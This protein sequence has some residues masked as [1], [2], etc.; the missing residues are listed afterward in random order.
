M[1]ASAKLPLLNPNEFEL[2][3]MRI[4]QYFLMKDYALWEVILNGDSLL[5]TRFVDGV[6]K[7]YPPIRSVK[8]YSSN[9]N[10]IMKSFNPNNLP[11][12]LMFTFRIFKF[13]DLKALSSSEGCIQTLHSEDRGVASIVTSSSSSRIISKHL[14]S[15]A[16]SFSSSNLCLLASSCS[17]LLLALLELPSSAFLLPSA[18][19]SLNFVPTAVITNSCK[20][21]V[22]TAKQSSLRAAASTSTARNINTAATRPTVNDAKPSSNDQ[23]I[24]DSE[25]SR[26]ITGNKSFLIDYQEINGG[27][28]AFGGSPKGDHLGKFKG[29]AD[30][31]FLVAYSVNRNQ[32]NDDVGIEINVNVKQAGQEKASDHEYILLSFMPFHSPL[33]LSIQ[34]SDDKDADEAPGKGDEGLQINQKDVGIFISHDKYVANI[35]KKFDFTTVKTTSTPIEPNKALIKDAEAKDVDVHL[36]RSMI[37]ILMY[38]TASRPDIMFA[39]CACA[40]DSPFDLEAF[41]DSDYAGASLDRKSTTGG[42]Q[43]LGKR[44]ISWQYKKQTIVANSTTKAEYVAAASCCGHVLWIQNQMLDYGLNFMNTKIYIDNESIICIVKNPVFHSKTKHIEIRHH[45][46]RDS[47]E[48][49]L[50]QMG[51][52]MNLEFKLV[53]GQRLVL[54]G[55]LDWIATAAKIEI[56]VKQSSMD[57]FSE[58]ITAVL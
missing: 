5:P 52:V 35:L 12:N 16:D 4:E 40:R 15:S 2:W 48:K 25:C 29:K 54:N 3:K 19:F 57:G 50:I 21:S 6:E 37:G 36:Y 33:S 58:M 31:G 11:L 22:N 42:Y 45:F 53:V 23:G 51:F 38:L 56:Q 49:K 18:D 7:A 9:S 32:T 39:V 30:E 46:I 13:L 43:F 24:F 1:V 28:I 10:I 47:Y 44:L 8:G 26:N 27:F 55:C 14:L 20:V 41:F 34:S 17:R